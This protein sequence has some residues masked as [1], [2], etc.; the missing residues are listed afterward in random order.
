MAKEKKL[1]KI[2]LVFFATVLYGILY[3]LFLIAG[4][5]MFLMGSFVA[6]LKDMG[7][8]GLVIV[9]LAIGLRILRELRRKAL[10][11]KVPILVENLSYDENDVRHYIGWKENDDFQDEYNAML[12]SFKRMSKSKLILM[13]T[14]YG[15]GLRGRMETS[16]VD[17][18]V[19]KFKQEKC[20]FVDYK[21]KVPYLLNSKGHIFYLLPH[22]VLKVAGRKDV[23]AFPYSSLQLE[24]DTSSYILGYE[25]KVPKDAEVL[26]RVYEHSNKNGTRDHR[27][28]DNDS[29]PKIKVADLTSDE[30]DIDYMISNFEATEQFFDDYIEFAKKSSL[31]AMVKVQLGEAADEINHA[32]DEILPSDNPEETLQNFVEKEGEKKVED[33]VKPQKKASKQSANP[34]KELA[35]LIGLGKVKEEI[36]TLTNLVKV[37]QAREKEG[38]KN[39]TMSYHL[40]FTGNPGTGKTTIARIIASIYKDLGILSKGHLVETDRSGLV[41]EYLGQ[42][43]VKTNKIIDDA[44]DGVL[45]IDEAYTLT[46]D[47][48]SYGKEAVATLLKR[49]EDDRDR[50]VVIL[51]G[52]TDNM[53]S[54]IASNPG[55]ESRFNRYID[56]PDYNEEELMQI[57]MTNVNKYEYNLNDD[58]KEIVKER[59]RENIISKDKQFGNA[60]FIRNMFEL[61]LANQANRLAKDAKLSGEDLKEI[62]AEDCKE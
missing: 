53:Q 56:F 36:N 26:G 5:L 27:V 44:L 32:M 18:L 58:A 38:L 4:M 23:V 57:F 3:W 50:L 61:I 51:A 19:T 20:P 22:F 39:S 46:D 17:T 28:K 62:T 6:E 2:K 11:K 15:D 16:H 21:S 24:Y 13:I 10:C 7:I 54:F 43:A 35:S 55:L 31:S 25:D 48:D 40:V 8:V 47:Q 9:V 1:K 30:F 45:F 34:Y 37:Q 59:I 33:K 42:T 29:V 14:H 12:S 49:M 41:A 60:R 52:Y